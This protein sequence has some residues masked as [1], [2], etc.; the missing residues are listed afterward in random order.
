MT[1]EQLTKVLA[2]Y[3]FTAAKTFAPQKGYRNQSYAVQLHNGTMLNFILYK[4]EPGIIDR[5]Q[6]ANAVSGRAAECGLPARATQDSQIMRIRAGE[7]YRYG[8]LYHYLPGDTIPWE[9][10]TKEH[11]KL[12]GGTLSSLHNA[13]ADWPPGARLPSVAQEYLATALRMQHYFATPTVRTAIADKLGLHVPDSL[14]GELQ[15]L[16]RA[17]DHLPK[18]QALHM[19]FVRSNILFSGTTQQAISG[20]LDFEKT[21]RGHRMFDIARTLAFLLVDCKYKTPDKIRRYFIDSGYNKRGVLDIS[22]TFI[23]LHGQR[24]DLLEALIDLFLV[25]DFYK[26][27]RHNPYES[28]HLNQ[29]YVRTRQQLLARHCIK[30][31]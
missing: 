4:D 13:L 24:I 25:H 28:L 26:F 8:S 31:L 21:A 27:L 20:I 29:H 2:A 23:R 1:P 3:G 11:I 30:E 12:L 15:Q 14:F 9:A 6:R 18:Q 7:R 17:C 5:I 16:L 22:Q 19:D 10:Y